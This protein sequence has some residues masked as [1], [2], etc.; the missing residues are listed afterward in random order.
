MNSENTD[1][2]DD[3]NDSIFADNKQ[4][5][6]VYINT[7]TQAVSY[8]ILNLLRYVELTILSYEY[9]PLLHR[10][11]KRDGSKRKRIGNVHRDR[12]NTIQFIRSWDD[13]MFKCQFRLCREDFYELEQAIMN[14]KTTQGYDMGRHYTFA[15][16]SSG[17][18]ITLELR[19]FIT[20]RLLSGASYLDMVWS[21]SCQHSF[22]ILEYYLCYRRG[23]G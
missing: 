21:K 7:I 12:S 11:D 10:R 18:P 8:A 2:E 13:T 19:L 1:S 23:L 9:L 20:M 4:H 17:S 16:R 22:N 3:D 14:H 6:V 5:P 15:C